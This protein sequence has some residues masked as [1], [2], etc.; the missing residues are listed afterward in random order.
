M[1][2]FDEVSV[3][4]DLFGLGAVGFEISV[5]EFH[6]GGHE[7]VKGGLGVGVRNEF[8]GLVFLNNSIEFFLAEWDD[9]SSFVAYSDCMIS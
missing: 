1:L 6:G 8:L 5:C 2:K 9:S 3:L 4:H 7:V